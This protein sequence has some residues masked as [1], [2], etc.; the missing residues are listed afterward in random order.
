MEE[1]SF[2]IRKEIE[3][4]QQHADEA[5]ENLVS[6]YQ[7]PPLEVNRPE[8]PGIPQRRAPGT[9]QNNFMP[10]FLMQMHD[11]L[12][13]LKQDQDQI[14]KGL[15][16]GPQFG[17]GSKEGVSLSIGPEALR[18]LLVL[19]AI[20]A[21]IGFFVVFLGGDKKR[22]KKRLGKLKKEIKRLRR[23]RRNPSPLDLDDDDDD[24][25]DDDYAI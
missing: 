19:L 9:P 23:R 1:P 8:Q 2:S 10:S 16:G 5:T 18:W 21:I 7:N 11:H 4:F 25:D 24:D 3:H 20:V 12:N 6:R 14:K 13:T 17:G 15:R 22:N